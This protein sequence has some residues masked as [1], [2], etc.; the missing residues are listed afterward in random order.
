MPVIHEGNGGAEL[1]SRSEPA[2]GDEAA[3]LA[4]R[5]DAPN[6]SVAAASLKNNSPSPSILSGALS[7]WS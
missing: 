7:E 5:R 6:L 3:P 2:S 4:A 1:P